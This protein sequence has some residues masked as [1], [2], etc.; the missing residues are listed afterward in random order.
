MKKMVAQL[1]F[2]LDFM[3][4]SACF[5]IYIHILQRCA[6]DIH[7]MNE[8]KR[9]KKSLMSPGFFPLYH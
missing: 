8:K 6:D 5:G 7:R 4:L 9:V 3:Y 2:Q 1:I